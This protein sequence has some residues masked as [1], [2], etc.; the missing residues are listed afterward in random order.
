MI[1]VGKDCMTAAA[2]A[3]AAEAHKEVVAGKT[4]E[5]YWEDWED[6]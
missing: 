3:P 5:T 4:G 2:D 6:W 1:T